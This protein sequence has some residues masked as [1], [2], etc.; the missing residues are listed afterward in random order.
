MK[1]QVLRHRCQAVELQQKWTHTE[2]VYTWWHSVSKPLHRAEPPC[3][4]CLHLQLFI[5]C[6]KKKRLL[7]G[8]MKLT[9]GKL[10]ATEDSK[11]WV[12]TT[13]TQHWV[14]Y[15]WWQILLFTSSHLY[16]IQYVHTHIHSV[17]LRPLYVAVTALSQR[18]IHRQCCSQNK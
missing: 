17:S 9:R 12:V 16:R 10:H 6:C 15:H 2:D 13:P 7:I 18:W 1:W 4:S 8:I 5:G 11:L 3:V 14:H